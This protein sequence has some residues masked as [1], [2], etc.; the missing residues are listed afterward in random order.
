[1]E[2]WYHQREE[3]YQ[4]HF[5]L[6]R[7]PIM[8]STDDA[9]PHIDIYQFPPSDDRDYW[10]LITGGMSNLPQTLADGDQH[11]T[12]LLM[13][14]REPRPWM[15]HAL[16]V[17]AEFPTRYRTFFHWG[18]TIDYGKVT[19][20]APTLLSAF[21]L[22]PPFFEHSDFDTLERDGDPMHFLWCIPITERERAYAKDNGGMALA[23]LM[24]TVDF[25]II[26]NEERESII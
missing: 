7:E 2:A 8:H 26:V 4:R 25:D 20:T 1:M 19:D 15:F 17:L 3:H 9:D 21:I 23:N 22:L 5:G 12:E 18:H 11:Y 13:Y 16:K 14:V 10:T 24:E 6:I